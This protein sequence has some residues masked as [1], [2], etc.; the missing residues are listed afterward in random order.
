LVP[1]IKEEAGGY[2]QQLLSL[3]LKSSDYAE[4]KGLNEKKE[5]TQMTIV[6]F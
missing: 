4:K 5:Q 2:V 6:D 3:L 1:A